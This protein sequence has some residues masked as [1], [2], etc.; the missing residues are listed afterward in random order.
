MAEQERP[1]QEPEVIQQDEFVPALKSRRSLA[2]LRRDLT[3]DDLASPGARKLLV[4]EIDYLSE[5][6]E[7]L[8]EYREKFFEADKRTAVLEER[9]HKNKVQEGM[10]VIC[11]AVGGLL[12]GLIPSMPPTQS[13]TWLW[14]V[15]GGVL[16]LG[17][18]LLKWVPK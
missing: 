9:L 12:L 7:K 18:G 2:K 8:T 13:Y 6:N 5:D 14:I 4:D 11:V 3:D 10:S 16:I 15:I 17:G 1:D